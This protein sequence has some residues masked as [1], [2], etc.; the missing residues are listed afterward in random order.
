MKND[1]TKS[2]SNLTSPKQMFKKI[3]QQKQ[4]VTSL[5]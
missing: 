5:T 4:Q 3:N 2:P 1:T